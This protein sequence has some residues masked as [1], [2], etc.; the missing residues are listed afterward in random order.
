MLS[1][2]FFIAFKFSFMG[3]DV[4]FSNIGVMFGTWSGILSAAYG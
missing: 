1:Y 3:I 2:L 4:N